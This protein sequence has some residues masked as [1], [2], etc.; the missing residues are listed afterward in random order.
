MFGLFERFL[1]V[2]D[3]GGGLSGLVLAHRVVASNGSSI[4]LC[5]L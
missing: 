1:T 5:I 3:I 4:E 2:Y